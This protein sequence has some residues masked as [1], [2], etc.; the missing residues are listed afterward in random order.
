MGANLRA[1]GVL[2]G[3]ILAYEQFFI[4]FPDQIMI[5]KTIGDCYSSRGE[6]E[7]AQESYMA[8]KRGINIPD[9]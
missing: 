5:L 3:A 2:T 6:I 9:Q 7:A 1:S 8:Y 4:N